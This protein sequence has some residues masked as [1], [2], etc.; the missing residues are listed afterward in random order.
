MV[1]CQKNVDGDNDYFYL[2][3]I[4]VVNKGF[5]DFDCNIEEEVFLDMIK[6]IFCL[7]INN[8]I[9]NN[10]LKM[11]IFNEFVIENLIKDVV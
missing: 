2:F 4:G 11:I 10:M 8:Y 5:I 7:I 3:S 9:E 1:F 6:M